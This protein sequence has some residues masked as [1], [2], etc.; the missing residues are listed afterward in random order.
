MEKRSIEK[1]IADLLEGLDF[2]ILES[3]GIDYECKCSRKKVETALISMGKEE[4]SGLLDDEK[5][6][7]VTCNF[8]DKVYTFTNEEIEELLKKI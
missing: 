8:C 6:I 2:E 5:P 1:V 3:H 7:S 4:L